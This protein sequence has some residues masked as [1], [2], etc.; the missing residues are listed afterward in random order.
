MKALLFFCSLDIF[1]FVLKDYNDES[2]S[3]PKQ[4]SV[5]ETSKTRKRKYISLPL[6]LLWHILIE[7]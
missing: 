7:T 2:S 3:V 6:F 1:F 4:C 5:F